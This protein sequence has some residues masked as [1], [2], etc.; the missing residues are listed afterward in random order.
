MSSPKPNFER[1]MHIIESVFATREDPN[2]LQVNDRV[3]KKLEA[4]HPDCLSEVSN[5]K[6]PLIWV[7]LIPT[8]QHIM[9]DF[10]SGKISEQELLD[11]T[12]EGI[13]YDSI[14]L[15]SATALPEMREKGETKKLCLKAIASI[16]EQ[17]PIH[18]LFV[19]A[20]SAEGE[21]LAEALARATHLPL[22]KAVHN[23]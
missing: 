16:R 18:S 19:W 4:L 3:I 23:R 21:K 1:M 13:L 14:Y 15:C 20:F 12:P 10:I 22:L 9:S 17:H 5:D 8:T 6:G 2:Q 11:Q 7:L